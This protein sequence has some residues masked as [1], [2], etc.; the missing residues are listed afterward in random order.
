M[1]TAYLEQWTGP[2]DIWDLV[3]HDGDT[4]CH[5]PKA[6]CVA[7]AERGGVEII[8]KS[9]AMKQP[10]TTYTRPAG[11]PFAWSYSKLKNFETCPKRHWHVDIAKDVVEEESEQLK[12]GNMLHDAMAKRIGSK[13]PLP[14]TFAEFEPWAAKLDNFRGTM[15]VEQKL[16]IQKDFSPCTF[17]DKAAW[18]RG[19]ADVLGIAGPVALC[20][21]W[22]TGKIV[23]DSVQLALTAQCVFAHYPEVQ[24][25]RTEFIWLKDEATT[26]ADFRREDMVGLWASLQPRVQMLEEA[27]KTTTYMAKP[28]PFCRRWCPVSQCPHHGH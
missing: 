23:E 20:M 7:Y 19:I 1:S 16:A 13:T 14:A 11:K 27:H 15:L 28:G 2:Y 22:K 17:F 24:A 9:E 10:V 25:V 26:R 12:Y 5:G 8:S 4:I 21:D 18:F 6:T 3:G